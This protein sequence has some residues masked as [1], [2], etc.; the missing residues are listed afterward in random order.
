MLRKRPD[1]HNPQGYL[2]PSNAPNLFRP[3]LDERRDPLLC[4]GFDGLHGLQPMQSVRNPRERRLPT[5]D[6][7]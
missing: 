7:L 5:T 6:G 1:G 3:G 4:I 2:I